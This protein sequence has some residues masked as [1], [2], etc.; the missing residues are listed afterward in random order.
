MKAQYIAE[1]LK[2]NYAAQG[3]IRSIQTPSRTTCMR[4]S[5]QQSTVTAKSHM[6]TENAPFA[7]HYNCCRPESLLTTIHML[8]YQ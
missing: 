1:L 7:F 2:V 8:I 6:D 4:H 3:H 5:F